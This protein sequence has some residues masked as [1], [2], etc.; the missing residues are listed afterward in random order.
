MLSGTT[1][2]ARAISVGGNRFAGNWLGMIPVPFPACYVRGID[3][4]KSDF[5][6]RQL[7][8]L[9][10]TWQRGGWW[11]YYL[12]ALGIKLPLGVLLLFAVA[13]GATLCCSAYRG[14][15]VDEGLLVGS[16]LAI[17]LLVSSQTGFSHHAHYA[18]PALPFAFVWIG[19]TAVAISCRQWCLGIPVLVLTTWS[20]ASSLWVYPHCYSYFNELVGG[21][22]HGAEYL[23]ESNV[24]WGQDLLYLKAWLDRHPEATPLYASGHAFYDMRLAGIDSEDPPVDPAGRHARGTPPQRLGVRPGW[25]AV[26]V[27]RLHEPAG[28]YEY[29]KRFRPL[30]MVTYSYRIYHVQFDEANRLRRENG[31]P[32][33]FRRTRERVDDVDRAGIDK[34][35]VFAR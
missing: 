28:D 25:Y 12:F 7:S 10:G 3:K 24:A 5:D 22:C 23:S 15:F 27:C 34:R 17:L 16:M 14:T 33:L 9:N 30:E 2:H 29:L 1:P 18:I 31:L 20:V 32:E 35:H 21:P 8:F 26:N 19:K 13:F 4:Q 6:D 11:Y